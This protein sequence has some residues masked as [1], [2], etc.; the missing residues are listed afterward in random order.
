MHYRLLPG[1]IHRACSFPDAAPNW[2]DGTRR[3]VPHRFPF[4]VIYLVEPGI[5]VVVAIALDRRRP[6]YWTG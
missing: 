4:S 6:T 1:A 3:V 5:I 2:I